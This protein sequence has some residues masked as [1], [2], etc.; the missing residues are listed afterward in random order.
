[1]KGALRVFCFAFVAVFLGLWTTRG[2]VAS[3]HQDVAGASPLNDPNVDLTDHFMTREDVHGGASTNLLFAQLSNPSTGTGTDVP[4]STS[5]QY[6]IHVTRV[7]EANKATTPS[8][9]EDVI[10]RFQFS[11]PDANGVQTISVTIFEDGKEISR[12]ESQGN[13]SALAT[14][15]FASAATPTVNTFS[16][17]GHTFTLFAG[18]REDPA[19]FDRT[20]WGEVKTYLRQRFLEG[21]VA[22]TTSCNGEGPINPPAPAVTSSITLFKQQGGGL[23]TTNSRLNR[24]ANA[25]VFSVP[26]AFLQK[27]VN[28]TIFDSWSSVS[29]PK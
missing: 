21:D 20:K 26:I 10:F 11:A 14:T 9:L 25:I 29:I 8:G 6:L 22:A 2:S 28:H 5:A 19:Y 18:L 7:T 23:C 16:V 15:P 17:G 13:G 1:M 27:N 3:D 12:I 24:N 4:F